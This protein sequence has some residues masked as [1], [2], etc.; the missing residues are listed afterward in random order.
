MNHKLIELIQQA[1]EQLKNRTQVSKGHAFWIRNPETGLDVQFTGRPQELYGQ[2]M[3]WEFYPNID[4][5]LVRTLA[6]EHMNNRMVQLATD[7]RRLIERIQRL[8]ASLQPEPHE[9]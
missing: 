9:P 7:E 1:L 2:I 4:S 5:N 6:E 8:A 3:G